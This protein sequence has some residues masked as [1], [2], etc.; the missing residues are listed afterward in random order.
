MD[1]GSVGGSEQ[2]SPS[3]RRRTKGLW[4]VGE[5]STHPQR[6]VR[7]RARS[8][9]ARNSLS[10][11]VGSSATNII[12]R[13]INKCN[14]RFRDPRIMEEPEI[15]WELGK[16]IGLA[17]RGVE[18]EVVQEYLCMEATDDEFVK[19]LEEGV[20]TVIYVDCQLEY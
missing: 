17:C 3:R 12:D 18:E 16:N 7:I 19:K 14:A 4:E 1:V 11:K 9:Q 10:F 8:S 2:G 13:D 20:I 15:L 5:P 6:S